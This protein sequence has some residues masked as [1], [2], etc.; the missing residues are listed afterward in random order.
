MVTLGALGLSALLLAIAG[1]YAVVSYGVAQRTHEFG[2]RMAL[3]ARASHI[4]RGAVG[5]AS[6]LVALGVL[7]GLVL[8]T[9]S[10][11]LVSD[12][13]YGIKPFGPTAFAVVTLVN[14]A[15]L[16]SG[17]FHSGAARRTSIRL[18]RYA[19]NKHC[20]TDYG[21]GPGFKSEWEP[22]RRQR[23][24]SHRRGVVESTSSRW[25]DVKRSNL[26]Y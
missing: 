16:R 25:L 5:G 11:R 18:R 3:G 1:I 4:V 6:V 12:Q 9:F 13:L 2:V 10:A 21:V 15:S 22:T 24:G 7:V 14:R 17:R 23:C 19:T 26:I 8:G 20:R